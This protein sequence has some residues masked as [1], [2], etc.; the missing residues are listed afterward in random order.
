MTLIEDIAGD[1]EP[2][3]ASAATVPEV[4]APAPSA[5]GCIGMVAEAVQAL[6]AEGRWLPNLLFMHRYRLVHGY[7]RKAGYPEPLPL[8][9]AVRR[10]LVRLGER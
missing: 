1:V 5:R 6:K 7:W 8:R 10:A 2:E 9:E 3:A 4:P